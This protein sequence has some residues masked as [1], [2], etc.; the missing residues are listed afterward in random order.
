LLGDRIDARGRR[1]AQAGFDGREPALRQ[2]GIGQQRLFALPIG[3][4]P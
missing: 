3:I 2:A 1:A 4:G